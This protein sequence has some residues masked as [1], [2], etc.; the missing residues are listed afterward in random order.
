M[1]CDAGKIEIAASDLMAE[2]RISV[3]LPRLFSLRMTIAA[4]LFRLAGWVS[5][6]NV[7]VEVSD[8]TLPDLPPIN[9]STGPAP[10]Y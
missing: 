10:S 5:G 2:L 4:S 7:V 6:T 8:A 1:A 3:R 9:G